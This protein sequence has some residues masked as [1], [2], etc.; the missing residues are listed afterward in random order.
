M[1]TYQ[2]VLD[3]MTDAFRARDASA[4]LRHIR[5]P[6]IM[7]TVD[8]SITYDDRD[9]MATSFNRYAGELDARGIDRIERECVSA[10]FNAH[11][12]LEGY[13]LTRLYQGEDLALDPFTTHLLFERTEDGQWLNFR[14]E[15]G[16]ATRAWPVLPEHALGNPPDG[17]E[18]QNFEAFGIFQTLLNV[19]TQHYLTGNLEGLHETV[20]YPLHMHTRHGELVIN[21]FA[22]LKAD[23]DIYLKE[24]SIH[25]VTD[26]LRTVKNARFV[27]DTEI[28]GTYKTYIL[29]KERL[30]V[31]PYESEIILGLSQAGKWRMRRVNHS[32]GHLNWRREGVVQ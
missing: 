9:Q 4:F 21:N 23:F 30:V 3:A 22:D 17:V 19:V 1:E 28:T 14:S 13:H 10:R 16:L 32:L 27:S 15:T 6:N 26:V 29:N 24:F 5:L 2:Q 31:D 8:G 12:I 7:A 11:G 20:E 25:G 18:E